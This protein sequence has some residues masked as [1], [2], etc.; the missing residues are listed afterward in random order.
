MPG[1]TSSSTAYNP[2]SDP[3]GSEGRR[4]GDYSFTCV[5]PEDDMT[6]WT[7]QQ[8]CSSTNTWGVQV[9]KLLAPPP[10][11]PSLST[12]A[13]IPSGES[14][15]NITVTG[16]S[17]NGS[18][19]FDP[20]PDIGGPGFSKHISATIT[21]GIVVN[22]IT[23]NSPTQVT[24]NISTIGVLEGYYDITIINPD[25]QS[26][27]GIGLIYIDPA[28]P[29]ELASFS[30]SVKNNS[31][32]L[33]WK[34]ETEVNNYGFEVE[35]NTPINPLSRGEAEGR[36]VWKKIG[37]VDGNGN[38]NSPK[39]YSFTDNDV[40]SGKY[41]YRLKQIDNDGKY[42]YSKAI[43]VDLGVP[44]KFELT[45][46]Y[47]NPFN[48][49][50]TIRFSILEA[51]DVKLTLFNILGQEIKSLVNEYKE[52]GIYTINLNASD[53]NSGIY[54]Y[55]LEAGSFVQSRKMTLIK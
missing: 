51:T 31:V 53:L 43:E 8:F 6:I 23:Y 26:A 2:P 24:L 12:P 54:I 39:T 14:S 46:N 13:A 50:T 5:D 41:Y 40:L 22:S 49:V 7:I 25:G 32:N 52:A 11:T 45:Q 48:P 3:G 28:L 47:P 35:R 1:Y 33:F 30:A 44:Q 16:T 55:K 17:V 4:W 21:G 37:F 36:G 20:G 42:E 34:T 9:A 38:S 10:V 27:T 19:F 15:L 29:V 18:G